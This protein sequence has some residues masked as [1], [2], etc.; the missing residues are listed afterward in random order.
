M[1]RPAQVHAR[2]R[3]TK[4]VNTFR[5]ETWGSLSML[6]VEREQTLEGRSPDGEDVVVRIEQHRVA[7][8]ES[9]RE[10]RSLLGLHPFR[11]LIVARFPEHST[12]TI[13]LPKL[14]LM[15]P[16]DDRRRAWLPRLIS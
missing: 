8:Y 14:V 7:P 11:H 2:L 3:T 9:G 6:L 1:N 12:W 5:V 4:K 15:P 16:L 10:A 13:T